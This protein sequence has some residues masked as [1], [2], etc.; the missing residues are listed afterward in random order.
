M[1][2][3][4]GVCVV[5][6]SESRLICICMSFSVR[7]MPAYDELKLSVSDRLFIVWLLSMWHDS[8]TAR[9]RVF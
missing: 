3:E 2:L 8:R 9:A 5:L 7:K 1:G 4:L 6:V